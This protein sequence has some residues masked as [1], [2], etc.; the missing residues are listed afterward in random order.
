MLALALIVFT[1]VVN[2]L[3]VKAMAKI[4]NFGVMAELIGARLA[5]VGDGEVRFV[6]LSLQ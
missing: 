3:G 2:I 5:F 4:N 6:A 1:T